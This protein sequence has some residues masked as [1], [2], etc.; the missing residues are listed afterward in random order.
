MWNI[1]EV[2]RRL[3]SNKPHNLDLPCESDPTLSA[4]VEEYYRLSQLSELSKT[5][6]ERLVMILEL[7]QYDAEL[8]DLVNFIDHIVA[9]ELGIEETQVQA[10]AKPV[11]AITEKP[12]TVNQPGCVKFEGIFWSAAF[13]RPNSQAVVA[14]GQPVSVVGIQGITLLVMPT[15]SPT[16]SAI[17]YSSN[18]TQAAKF[19]SSSNSIVYR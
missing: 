16:H 7:A 4:L 2:A 11:E 19:K 8:S 13:Y 6:L 3:Y 12:I 5:D 17:D 10:L 14:P 15:Y 9:Q 18:L 1:L